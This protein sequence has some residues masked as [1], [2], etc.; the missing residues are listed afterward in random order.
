ME[1]SE[2]PTKPGSGNYPHKIRRTLL[3]RFVS[4]VVEGAAPG[5]CWS[6][7]GAR[8]DFGYGVIG[9]GRKSQGIARAHRVSFQLFVGPIP[10]GMHVLHTCD[11][12]PC[13][14]PRHLRLGTN[15]RNVMDR[16]ERGRG[17]QARGSRSGAS[18]LVEAQIPEIRRLGAQGLNYSQIGRRFGVHASCIRSVLIGRTWK[19]VPLSDSA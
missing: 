19:H 13:C 18:S 17:N 5:D 12:P 8:V 10:D 3:D 7:T 11:N 16:E 6:W 1:A 14:N 2:K 9:L 15:L 4:K